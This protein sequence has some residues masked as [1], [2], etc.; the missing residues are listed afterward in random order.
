MF[1]FKEW[2]VFGS[3]IAE[4]KEVHLGVQ[5]SQNDE[6]YVRVLLRQTR[7]FGFSA[8]LSVYLN[9]QRD[10]RVQRHICGFHSFLTAWSVGQDCNFSKVLYNKI[11]V[12]Y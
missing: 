3:D 8:L 12:F 11:Q 6:A 1:Y 10:R 2:T 5:L 7:A 4:A 9:E